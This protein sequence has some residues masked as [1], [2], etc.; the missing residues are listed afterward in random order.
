MA[1]RRNNI[2]KDPHDHELLI[3]LLGV[4]R[5]VIEAACK[6]WPW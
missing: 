5:A 1:K 3:A 4:A 6:F 2:P